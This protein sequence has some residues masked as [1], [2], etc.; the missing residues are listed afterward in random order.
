MHQTAEYREGRKNLVFA[1][2]I[3]IP[4]PL[5]LAISLLDG[6]SATAVADL[7]RR[8]CELLSIL[9]AFIVFEITTRKLQD[10]PAQKARLE[11]SVRYFTG[12]SMVFSGLIM[13]YIAI[14]GFG[15]EKGSV[16]T[17]LVLAII[18]ALVN[19]KLYSN[20]RKMDHAVLSV[21]AKLHRVKM[22]LDIVMALILV[23]FTITAS[24]SIKNYTDLIGSCLIAVY[25]VWS[26]VR[27]FANK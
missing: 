6:Q 16:I 18:G 27:L 24:A 9:L 17:S 5:A 7:L 21:Q 15:G 20:Y 12:C 10:K 22:W 25:L 26:G 19:Y 8:S 3:S 4:G 1:V 11:A 2:F 13:I 14:A 23:V